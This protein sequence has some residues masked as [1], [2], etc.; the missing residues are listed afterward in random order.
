MKFLSNRGAPERYG[1]SS[2]LLANLGRDGGLFVPETFPRFNPSEFSGLNLVETGVKLLTPFLAGDPLQSQL[3]EILTE[4]LDFPIPLI[5]LREETSL[6]E[7]FHGPTH[8]F[9]DVGA[10]FLAAS[11]ARIP[12]AAERLILVATSGDTG[13]AVAAAFFGRPGTRVVVLYPL[14]LV[15]PRQEKQLIAW[16]GNVKA[17][18]VRGDFDDC[19]RMVKEAFREIPSERLVSANSISLGRLLPQMVYYAYSSVEYLARHGK[20]PGYIIP[21]GNLGNAMAAL[22]VWRMGFPIREV[23]LATNA[24]HAIPDYFSKPREARAWE[25][26]KTV[27]TSANAMDVGNASNMERLISLLSSD[28]AVPVR[29]VSVSDAEIAATIAG[30]EKRWGQV[31]CPHTAAG[32]FVRESEKAGDWIVVS[33]AHPAKFETIVEPLVGHSVE[34][35]AA[36]AEILK[37][38]ATVVPIGSGLSDLR[39]YLGV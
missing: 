12:S 2:A 4:A 35:P 32:V 10:R 36:L 37:K 18:A 38:P 13:G 22:W 29:A 21:T 25:P 20:A 26:R 15:S 3:R 33:T 5:G 8:A 14:G 1:F 23:V 16:G 31:F 30:G 34:V 17:L 39:P 27:A 28:A 19:Q 6:L 7:L 24:N 11:L 9:K